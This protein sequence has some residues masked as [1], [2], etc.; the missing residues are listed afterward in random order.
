MKMLFISEALSA[1]F[2][3]GVK[4]IAYSL[5]KQFRKR[6][7]ILCVTKLCNNTNDLNIVK[8]KLNKFFMNRGL[9]SLIKDYVPDIILYYPS[10]SCTFYSFIRAKILKL[11]SNNAKIVMMGIQHKRHSFFQKIIM[12]RM[13]KPDLIVLLGRSDEEFFREIGIDVKIL[14][15]AVD[16]EEFSPVSK[17]E[18]KMIRAKFNIPDNR[19]VVLHVG[20]IKTGRNIEC[21]IE[22]QKLDNIQVVIVGSTSIVVEDDLKDKL[23][24]AGI[25]IIDD[26]VKD[27]SK[28][29]KMSD[30]YVFPVLDNDEAIEMPLSVLEAMACNLPVVTTRFGGLVDNFEDDEGFRYFNTTKELI[31]LIDNINK[32]IIRN[33]EKIKHLT[34]DRF[35]NRI[36]ANCNELL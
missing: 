30:I 34:W 20:H 19:I 8:I 21:L 12:K 1:P 14:P 26:F 13:L 11:M 15:P 9:R 33:R 22:V 7:N 16:I 35:V 32:T 25:L 36:I 29:Y 31:E 5:Y 3:E 10:S 17:K 28:I 2:D 27:I 4:K 6:R 24:R 18:K 23:E